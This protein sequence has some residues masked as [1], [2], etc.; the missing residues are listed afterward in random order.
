[1]IDYIRPYW[2][3]CLLVIIVSFLCAFAFSSI[4]PLWHVF[5][6]LLAAFGTGLLWYI[7]EGGLKRDESNLEKGLEDHISLLDDVIA[8][9]DA[10]IRHYEGLL[11][12]QV[13]KLPCNCGETLF[14][15]ILTSENEI[16]ECQNCDEKYRIIVEYG[17]VLL[18]ETLEND[19]VIT[20]T[21]E[22]MKNVS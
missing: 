18:T 12:T 3:H 14:Q 2:K 15:G 5:T 16:V 10:V 21:L 1:M 6:G 13:I 8:E 22:K 9:K 19:K 17:T 7:A 4:L 20:K 11:D